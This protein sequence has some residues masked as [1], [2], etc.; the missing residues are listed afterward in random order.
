M[1]VQDKLDAKVLIIGGTGGIGRALA[2]RYASLES[3]VI[4]TSRSAERAE[5]AAKEIGGNTRGIA[6]DIAEP[7]NIET[8]L[9]DIGNEIDRLLIV[10]IERDYNTVREYD[11]AKA[12]RA[13]TVKIVGYTEVVHQLLDRF[14]DEASVVIFGGLAGQRPYPGSTTVTMVNG[15]VSSMIRTMAVELAPIRFNAIHPGIIGDTPA[16]KDKPEALE[17]VRARTPGGRLA[18]TADVVDAVKFLFNNKGVN[19]I[20]LVVDGGWMLQ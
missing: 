13:V 17:A 12:K 1:P 10:A 2:E 14:S 18:T 9:A 11:L 7:E 6:L 15:A 5:Q 16:W 20:N 4:L 8:Q 19:G 3:E